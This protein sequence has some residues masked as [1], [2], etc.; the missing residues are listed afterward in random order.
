MR[1]R[2]AKKMASFLHNPAAHLASFLSQFNFE[3]LL[4]VEDECRTR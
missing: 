1:R 4:Y 3:Y 2:E